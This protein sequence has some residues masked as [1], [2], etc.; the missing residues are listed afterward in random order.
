MTASNK[1]LLLGCFLLSV[2]FV[3]RADRTA[4][5]ALV[6]FLVLVLGFLASRLRF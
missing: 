1:F 4:G 3:F 6:M 5:V 2:P